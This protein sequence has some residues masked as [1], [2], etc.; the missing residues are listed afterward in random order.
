MPPAE[1]LFVALF[2]LACLPVGFLLGCLVSQ[3][4]HRRCKIAVSEACPSSSASVTAASSD[5][6]P[7]AV[8]ASANV[9]LLQYAETAFRSFCALTD[10]LSN[11][12]GQ[13]NER[14]A[15]VTTSLSLESRSPDE[16]QRAITRIVEANA[17]LQMQLVDAQKT[18]R[19]QSIE[20][21][22]RIL[23]ANTDGLTTIA[24]RRAFDLEL[25]RQ[26]AD[27]RRH[28][29]EFA[30]ALFDIDRFKQVND[31][32][33][34]LAGDAVLQAVAEI[35]KGNVREVDFVARY[36]GEEFAM[37]LRETD[38][39]GA[40]VVA[41]RVRKL[42]AAAQIPWQDRMLSVTV[43]VGVARLSNLDDAETI[44]RR[45]DEALYISKN[46]GRNRTTLAS[47]P[48]PKMSVRSDG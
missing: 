18:I 29:R 23:E 17:W 22:E 43:S 24:N 44:T 31:V 25:E 5:S 3:G 8:A 32:H 15:A 21:E 30:L 34:H 35:I 12:V 13:H 38:H 2:C 20:L 45:A 7:S 47:S 33:G 26:L 40:L 27:W 48:A 10:D 19:Q 39:E 14:L 16:L 37:I 4:R 6:P 42:I 36:G 28:K 46:A 1:L 11:D 9:A 41:D